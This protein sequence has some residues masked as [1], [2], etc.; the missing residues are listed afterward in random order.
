[1]L[2]GILA[3]GRLADREKLAYVP[4]SRRV[5]TLIGR[6]AWLVK[7]SLV[8]PNITIGVQWDSQFR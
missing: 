1:M 4:I 5:P 8:R 7:I 2:L 6:Q 3:N